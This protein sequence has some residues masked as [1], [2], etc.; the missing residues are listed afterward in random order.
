MAD[1]KSSCGTAYQT[2]EILTYDEAYVAFLLGA[3]VEYTFPTLLPDEWLTLGAL[4]NGFYHHD[5][6]FRLKQN[7]NS[8]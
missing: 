2:G 6:K 3:A 4:I 5:I 8:A 7:D 1:T